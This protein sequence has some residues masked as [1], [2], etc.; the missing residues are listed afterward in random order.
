MSLLH[1][2]GLIIIQRPRKNWKRP[3]K[4]KKA[5]SKARHKGISLF[6]IFLAWLC[7]PEE[8]SSCWLKRP[9]RPLLKLKLEIQKDATFLLQIWSIHNIYSKYNWPRPFFE[10]HNLKGQND[11]K[12]CKKLKDKKKLFNRPFVLSC[13]LLKLEM[14]C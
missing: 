11:H 7:S 10:W 5:K 14:G 1:V 12:G 6:H 4:V 2:T 8:W 3:M 13:K 9:K